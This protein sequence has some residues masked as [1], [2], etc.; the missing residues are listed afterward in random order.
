[1][2]TRVADTVVDVGKV[3]LVIAFQRKPEIK[4]SL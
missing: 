3:K 1:M 4:H 2:R